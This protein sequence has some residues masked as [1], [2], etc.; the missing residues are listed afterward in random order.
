MRPEEVILNLNWHAIGIMLG[1]LIGWSGLLLG[2]I[3][4]LVGR[5]IHAVD[6]RFAAIAAAG[7]LNAKEH[8]ENKLH[9]AEIEKQILLLRGELPREYVQREDWIRFSGVL[10]TKLDAIHR[11]LDTMK[12]ER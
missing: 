7:Q 6:E 10:E 5:E 8:E 12:D 11:R 3:K 4:W 1:L 9:H 2:A